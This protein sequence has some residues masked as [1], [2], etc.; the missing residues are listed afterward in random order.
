MTPPTTQPR[1]PR[2]N[3]LRRK[4]IFILKSLRCGSAKGAL[5]CMRRKQRDKPGSEVLASV[6]PD[7][8]DEGVV[9]PGARARLAVVE[10]GADQG[11]RPDERAVELEELQA[12]RR[13]RVR[14]VRERSAMPGVGAPYARRGRVV[15][16]RPAGVGELRRRDTRRGA[17]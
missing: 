6:V 2:R 16:T 14:I 9:T 10:V 1:R 13:R 12:V 8:R 17:A 4:R 15:E 5:P 11:Q 3:P 7:G